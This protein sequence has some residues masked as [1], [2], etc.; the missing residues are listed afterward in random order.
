[1]DTAP[2]PRQTVGH[3]I[4]ARGAAPVNEPQP[5]PNRTID[6]PPSSAAAPSTSQGGPTDLDKRAHRLPGNPEVTADHTPASPDTDRTGGHTPGRETPS[7]TGGYQP[8][9]GDPA[10]GVPGFEL[11]GELGRGGMGVVYKA[12]QAAL[13]RVVALKMILAGPHAAPAV[14]ARFLAEARAVARFQHPNIVQIFEV[15][16]AGGLPYFALEFVDGVTLAKR[17]ARSPQDPAYAAAVAAQ[18]ARAVGYA[19][20]QGVVHR[21]L[22][23]ANVLLTADGT[24]KVTDF[25]LAKFDEDSSQTQSGQVLGTPSYMAPEQAEGRADVGPAADVWALG[26]IL[27]DLLTGR[28]PFAGSSVVD[29]LGM[30][31][32][33]EPVPPGQ[34]ARVPRDLETICL[35]CLQK[36]PA[37]RYESAAAL[38]DDLDRYREGKPILARPVS[39]S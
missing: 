3:P 38:A 17:I 28:P 33:R 2:D 31:R 4:D 15:G 29:T 23:P 19:H 7:L 1:M 10:D 8:A 25:G 32:T 26:A 21:D 9:A 16:E 12:R 14:V 39:I 36:D 20:S 24:P 13:G 5:D 35:K 11:L 30:V 6:Q 22:K 18:L 34:L 27:Y 37:R